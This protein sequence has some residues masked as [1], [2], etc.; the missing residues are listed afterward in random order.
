MAYGPQRG[1]LTVRKRVRIDRDKCVGC[2]LCMTFCPVG[3]VIRLDGKTNT[4]RVVNPIPCGGCYLCLRRC[5]SGA[6]VPV[7]SRVGMPADL[8]PKQVFAPGQIR[9]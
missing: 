7:A 3:N 4:A 1:H 8:E 5:P 9:K 6:I 2:K